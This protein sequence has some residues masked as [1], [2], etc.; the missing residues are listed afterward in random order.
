MSGDNNSF[1]HRTTNGA[2]D[3]GNMQILNCRSPDFKKSD[4]SNK[5]KLESHP[6]FWDRKNCQTSWDKKKSPNLLGQKITHNLLGQ[7]K[8]QTLWTKKNQPTSSDKKKSLNL[9]GQKKNHPTSQDNKKSPKLLGQK[10][11][12]NLTG[13]LTEMFLNLEISSK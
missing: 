9:S 10:K 11:S 2:K 6:T 12:P 3:N 13:Q 5:K 7:K 1:N 8:N 4:R